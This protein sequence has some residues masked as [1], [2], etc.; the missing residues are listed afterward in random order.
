MAEQKKIDLRSFI[1]E[2]IFR[3]ERE[4]WSKQHRVWIFRG[5]DEP[6]NF[7]FVDGYHSQHLGIQNLGNSE[8]G[9]YRL[10]EMLPRSESV[11]ELS[12]C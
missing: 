2:L 11:P 1:I 3:S 7:D 4:L 6:W 10:F 12:P 9:N 5:L 8:E